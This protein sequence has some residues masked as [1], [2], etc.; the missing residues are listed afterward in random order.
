MSLIVD[1]LSMEQNHRPSDS[2]KASDTFEESENE[3]TTTLDE[4]HD[5][6][7]KDV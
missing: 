4:A 2:E 5:N 7:K 3:S 1:K 6:N